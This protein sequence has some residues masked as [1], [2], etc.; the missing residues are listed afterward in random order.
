[1]KKLS[2]SKRVEIVNN[3]LN[4]CQDVKLPENKMMNWDD[5]SQL[6][7]AG[8]TIGSHSHT[9]PMLAALESEKEIEEEKYSNY[10]WRRRKKN[11]NHKETFLEKPATSA[12][13]VA[14]PN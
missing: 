4:Q 9:H 8:F 13:T 2:N 5:I 7:E 10:N 3:I 6:K 11:S 14:V 12:E 1:M